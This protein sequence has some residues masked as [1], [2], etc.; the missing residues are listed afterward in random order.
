MFDTTRFIF[1]HEI[2]H[3]L[4]DTY[5]LPV[6]ANEEDAAD[7]CSSFINLEELGDEGVRAVLAA[8]EDFQIESRQ[9]GGHP[10]NMADEHLLQEQ[11]FYLAMCM[12]YGSNPDKYDSILTKHYLPEER[13]KRCPTE[14]QKTVDSWR[15]LLEPWRKQ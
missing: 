3:A 7:R 5:K 13:A 15:T 14:Y 12:L 2:G 10:H 11:R 6:T 4:I 9:N 1:L 8:S